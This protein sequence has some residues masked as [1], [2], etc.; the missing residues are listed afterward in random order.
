[1]LFRYRVGGGRGLS[2]LSLAMDTASRDLSSSEHSP[3]SNSTLAQV[4]DDCDRLVGRY[5]DDRG[6]LGGFLLLLLLSR[7]R[8]CF[9][10]AYTLLVAF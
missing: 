3:W 9:C 2:F 1:M 4:D 7:Y 10:I 8:V 5:S 6:S